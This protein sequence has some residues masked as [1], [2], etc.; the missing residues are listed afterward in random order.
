MLGQISLSLAVAATKDATTLLQESIQKLKK[1]F[2]FLIPDNSN[3]KSISYGLKK[4]L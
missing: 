1:L 4:V 3:G 2:L